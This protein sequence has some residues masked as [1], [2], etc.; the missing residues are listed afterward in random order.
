M[1]DV[2][3]FEMGNE[4]EEKF[5]EILDL[6]SKETWT[7][8][9][10]DK[11]SILF[12]SMEEDRVRQSRLVLPFTSVPFDDGV[13]YLGF[14]LEPNDYRFRDWLWLYEKIEMRVSNFQIGATYGCPEG[15]INITEIRSGVGFQCTSFQ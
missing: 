1:D 5:K 12:N 7:E 8:V 9:N 11:Y 13:Q 4:R 10:N 14:K 3:L 2:I 15:K 6:Y